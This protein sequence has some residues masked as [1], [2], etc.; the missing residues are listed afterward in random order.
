VHLK[1]IARVPEV[2]RNQKSLIPNPS[3]C[4]FIPGAREPISVAILLNLVVKKGAMMQKANVRHGQ[5]KMDKMVRRR[6]LPCIRRSRSLYK[7]RVVR[8]AVLMSMKN[9]K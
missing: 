1:Y 2:F 3:S 9:K 6:E 7:G 5:I 8:G 4:A